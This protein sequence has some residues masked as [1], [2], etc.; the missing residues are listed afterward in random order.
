[1]NF[2]FMEREALERIYN[3]NISVM[4]YNQIITAIPR[5]WKTLLQTPKLTNIGL[6]DRIPYKC[7]CN[8]QTVKN[9]AEE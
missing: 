1:M 9:N 5:K 8:I 7:S 6:S 4:K 3:I 2:S